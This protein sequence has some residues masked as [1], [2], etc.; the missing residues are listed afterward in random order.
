MG[1]LLAPNSESEIYK[2][3]QRSDRVYVSCVCT[4]YNQDIYIRDAIDGF[5]AQVTEYRFEIIIH[6]DASSD[7]TRAIL[8]E[9]K[10]KYPHIIRLILQ[11]ENQYSK[12]NFRPFV[13]ASK[14]A[15]GGY[16]ALCEGDDYWNDTNKL[17]I[18]VNELENNNNINMVITSAF[19]LFPDDSSSIFCDLGDEKS[20][21]PFEKCILGPSKDFY[22][23]ASFLFRTEL[24]QHL[25]DWFYSEAPV[26]DYYVQ[27]FGSF[28]NGCIYLPSKSVTYRLNS[29]GSLSSMMDN[30]KFINLRKRSYF[31]GQKLLAMYGSNNIFKAA[32]INKQIEYLFSLFIVSF[33][34]KR[35]KQSVKY[36]FRSLSLSIPLTAK[37]IFNKVFKKISNR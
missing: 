7:N 15:K 28:P 10:D 13:Y 36:L 5:L 17:Q 4:T 23:T 19:S 31:C 18:Q 1:K 25:P 20:I 29:V 26:G 14:I 6:D 32:I 8:E 30:Q 21:I 22:P 12:G 16:I 24:L 33:K 11:N 35:Y 37:Y 27:L 2:H 34:M 9:Y 3:W